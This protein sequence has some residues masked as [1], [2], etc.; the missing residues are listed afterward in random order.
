[1]QKFLIQY[2]RPRST[3]C[4]FLTLLDRVSF[5]E[6]CKSFYQN[7]TFEDISGFKPIESR[8]NSGACGIVDKVV[9]IRDNKIFAWKKICLVHE[10]IKPEEIVKSIQNE[11]NLLLRMLDQPNILQLEELLVNTKDATA[12]IVTEYCDGGDLFD[13]ILDC[14]NRKCGAPENFIWMIA[15]DMLRALKACH[16]YGIIHNDVKT[17]NILLNKKHDFSQENDYPTFTLCDFGV[18]VA[19]P[20]NNY[21]IRVKTLN[22]TPQYASP[23]KRMGYAFNEKADIWSLG[24]VLYELCQYQKAFPSD[25]SIHR[26]SNQERINICTKIDIKYSGYLQQFIWALLT[27]DMN[28]RP[29]AEEAFRTVSVIM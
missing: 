17:E 20:S 24:C 16:A 29:S 21:T 2:E 7:F 10:N 12:V 26:L 4:Q 8:I 23:E 1:M 14:Y 25:T 22:G 15:Y 6:A 9:R 18:A 3:I 13:V 27:F 28:K 11:Y 19:I 5:S